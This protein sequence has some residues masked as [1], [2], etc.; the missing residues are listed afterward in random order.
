MSDRAE[1]RKA[2]II[3]RLIEELRARLEPGDAAL[4]ERFVQSYYRDVAPGDLAARD[5]LDLY[6][7]ALAQ[8]RFAQTRTPGQAKVRAYNP[9]LEQHGWQ[10]THTIVEVVND[11][12]PFLVDSVGGELSR[13]GLGI[14][15]IIHP[16][17][18]VRRDGSGRL[19]E[20]VGGA[21]E[22][23]DGGAESV[24]HFEVDRQ[25]DQALLDTVERDLLRVLGDVRRTVDD[26]RPM[27]DKV[28][29]ALDELAPAARH[30]PADE[31]AETVAFLRWLADDHF[32]FMGY[33]RY[34]IEHDESGL[35]LRRL[36]GSGLGIL[37]GYDD[38]ALSKSFTE[39]PPEIR[40]R[41]IE[42]TPPLVVT[43]ANA[44]S[45]VHRATYLDFIGIKRY[46]GDGTV[47]GEHRFLGL[48]TSL[49]YN[50]N[51]RHIP[52][53]RSKVEAVVDRSGVPRGGHAGKALFH[54]LETLPRD[55]L[56]Q[57]PED[58]L[59]RTA[60]AILHLQDRQ[61]LRLFVRRDAFA[62]FVSCLVY[63]PRERYNTSVRERMQAILEQALGST[64]TEFQAHI[65][66][67]LLA[68]I[69]F[70]IRTP[71]GIPEGLDADDLERKLREA[72]H[73]WSD[74]LK[75]AL[76]ESEG[77]EDGNRLYRLYG[78]A[79]PTGYQETVPA[80]AAVRDILRIDALAQDPSASLAMSLYRRLEDPEDLLRFK[81]IR[82]D[83][84]VQLSDALPILENMGLRVLSE[85]PHL[86]RSGDSRSFSM[87]DFGIR[88]TGVETVDVDAVRDSFQE[89]FVQVWCDRKENDGFNRLVLAAG[90]S[91]REITVLRAY[92]KY[93]LQIGTPFSQAY[94]EQTLVA[95]A[96]LARR[97]AALF[98]ARLDPATGLDRSARVAAIESEI[99]DGLQHVAI[100]DEDRILRRYL[101]MIQATLRT[102]AFQPD[103]ATGAAKDYVSIKL[104]PKAVPGMPAPRPAFEI[105]VYAPWMEGLHLRGGKV[106]RGGLRWSDRREDFRTEVLG[107]MKAQMVKNAVI[108][109]VGAKGGFVV[110]RPPPAAD[111]AAFHEEGIRCYRTLLKG[112]LDITDNRVQGQIVPPAHV[113]RHDADDPYLVVAADKGTATF[114]DIANAVSRDYGFWLDDAFASGGSAGYDH[115]GMGITA[116]GAWESVRRHF[117]ELG[118]DPEHDT[119]T[120]MGIGDMSGDVFG[121]GMLLSASMKLVAAFDHRH[122]FLDP[123]PDPAASFEERR[124]LF[125]LPRSSWDDYDRS[126]ISRGGAVVPR[127]QKSIPLSPEIREVLAVEREVMTPAELMSAILKAPV[128]LFWN[129]GIGTYVKAA[130]ESHHDAQDRANDAIRVDGEELRCKVVAEGGNLGFTQRGRIAYALAGGRI[131]TD[132]IDN[133]AG[134]DCSDHEVNIKILLGAVVA[135]GDMTMKQ[136]DEL[137][138]EMTDEVGRLVLRDN[139]LQNLALSMGQ[140]GAPDFLDAQQRLMRKLEGQGRLDR[141]LELLP[142][143][144]VLADRRKAGRGLTRPEAAVLL[145]YAK[146]T[147]YD[148][149]L[150]SEIPDREYFAGDLTKYF[151]RPL[152][153]RFRAE[154]EQHRLRR[155]IVATWVANSLVNRGLD[156]FVSELED[157]TGADL[158]SITLAYVIARDAFALLPL[159]AEIEALGREVPAEQ[160]TRMLLEARRVLFAGTR[161]FLAHGDRP[162]RIRPSVAR[163]RPGIA[164]MQQ[165]LESVLCEPH[166]TAFRDSVAG[167]S[168]A[169]A[170][171]GLA[172]SMAALPYML[173]GC[174]IVALFPVGEEAGREERLL[175]AARVYA[176]LDAELQLGGLRSRLHAMPIRSRWDRMAVSALEDELSLVLRRLTAAAL[177]AGVGAPAADGA[178]AAVGEWL[179]RH[180]HG[181]DRYRALAQE[182]EAAGESDLAM[183][184][185]AVR[186]LGDL[187]RSI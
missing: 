84:P 62:R 61:Q 141:Q 6:G 25:S 159:W 5:L 81:L 108:V 89:L 168:E 119:C 23:D 185:V 34:A 161:W 18:K 142:T 145:A 153:R 1:A 52:L 15:L 167:W 87:H 29:E 86:V 49:A 171:E 10:S 134:V 58:E 78:R 19:L 176:A 174:D 132:F 21:C 77:E 170:G 184:T 8:L 120:V 113:V 31:F 124:R 45:T 69:L 178:R 121:N 27:R 99:E 68:R 166:L 51:P 131:N 4:A 56:F 101:G 155:E 74:R 48:F 17:M 137:L 105:F 180:L 97:L 118:L 126:L 13:H 158:E 53:L 102:N 147:L 60:T 143:D 157:E 82:P 42:P 110:K 66:E 3:Q 79:F 88:P 140:A 70:V 149:L 2:E 26:W 148:D 117:R 14:H 164:A 37:K 160:Q 12:M 127:S 72:A 154:I 100:L 175:G 43:K 103:A 9:V 64:E 90:L 122:I 186:A 96:P 11:D 129:G 7:T 91:P 95:N 71:R 41:A 94:I 30:L 59:F 38:G 67:G 35:Q 73:S 107:L 55:E 76:I 165:S 135:A 183:L 136:R 162:L 111:R 116:K 179:Q 146:M 125:A 115:K 24:M 112:M 177:A 144:A 114:S 39:L 173:P 16:V 22:A 46:D 54:I 65:S 33:S 44:K 163:W 172:R 150:G 138:A 50:L 169:G 80:R 93:L 133:S 182:L 40:A 104:D 128:D 63:I 151:P 32:T 20:V 109:P 92:C 85:E 139:V 83:R 28:A 152:R 98:W 130:A 187:S 106:A 181:L 123:D 36:K 75:E 57:T 47:L 156:V